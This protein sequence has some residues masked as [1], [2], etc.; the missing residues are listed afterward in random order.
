MAAITGDYLSLYLNSSLAVG[1]PIAVLSLIMLTL[2]RLTPIIT[3]APFFGAKV[4]PHPV[5]VGFALILFAIF[6]PKLLMVIST[7]LQ[8]NLML[9]FL[10]IKELFIGYVIGFLISMPFMIVQSAGILIDH[11]RGGASLMVND[12]TIQNQSSP[13]GTLFNMVLI[14][15]FFLIDGPFLF[16]DAIMTSYDVIPPDRFIN[17]SFWDK[18]THFWDL[19]IKLLNMV[20]TLTIQL[21]APA[22]I[23]ILMTDFFLGIANRLAP[24]VQI[25]FL[26][27][28]LKSLLAILVVFVGWRLFNEQVIKETYKWLTIINE[29]IQQFNTVHPS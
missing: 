22:L 25:T 4:L 9:I 6:L 15:M 18:N 29:T 21:A 10:M 12:P 20:M 1:E 8:F 28:P 24:Q 5:K 2:A 27:M 23:A 16:I 11:Q 7:P 3:M 19:Q 14:V 13:F 17:A 26:G